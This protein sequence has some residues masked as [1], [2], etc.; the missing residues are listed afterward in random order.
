MKNNFAYRLALT[1]LFLI[2]AAA[3]VQA[4]ATVVG[5]IILRGK[6]ERSGR[7][8]SN[9]TS[10]FE[11]DSLRTDKDSGGV[12][13]V[14]NGR[15]EIG[16]LTEVEVIH[17]NPLKLVIKSGTI[18]FN[19]PPQT[20]VEIVTPQLDIHPSPG[21]AALSGIVTATPQTE[22]RVQSRSGNFTVIELQKNGAANHIMPGQIVVAALIPT[23]R[24][25]TA[26]ADPISPEPQGPLGGPQIA[27][28]DLMQGDVRVARRA[29]PN[30]YARAAVGIGLASGDFVRTLNGRADVL[31]NPPDTSHLRLSEG[32]T[33]QIQ[34]QMQAA[35]VSRRVTQA[36][37]NLWFS[38]QRVTGTQT[39]LLTP[40]AVA[41]IRG[42]EGTQDVPNNTQSTHSL[43]EGIEQITEVVT[44]R[45][46]TIRNGQRVT[47]IRGV[48]FT[49][50]V[51]LLA[52]IA[53]PVIGAGGGG[54]GAGGAGGGAGG[55]AA[56]GGA[57]GG[58]T[59]A[60]TGATTSS[61]STVASVT[62]T[63]ATS[64][65]ALT[66]AVTAPI[67]ASPASQPA[68][69]SAPLVHPGGS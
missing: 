4:R 22:D 23:V 13:R 34:Q 67:V 43:N 52:A 28:I 41:A 65:A 57:A 30:N 64:A 44:S 20:A 69:S 54:G 63:A 31:F 48:G 8:L 58:A 10:V 7:Q 60:A 45:S 36:I 14:A 35:T 5:D 11:G 21:D 47:A 9:D 50:V 68:S 19:F 62:A 61:I 25:A 59:G 38:I 49:P 6:V 46:V 51:A 15:V 18:A 29:T 39:T 12:L 55:G 33:V 24:L 1:V 3:S 32:T 17:Q 2:S 16:E 27:S 56:G 66:V 40:T 37:G 53:Q 42:T 26:L